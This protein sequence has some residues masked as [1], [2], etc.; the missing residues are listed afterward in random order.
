MLRTGLAQKYIVTIRNSFGGDATQTYRANT[1]GNSQRPDLSAHD[2]C[3]L[4]AFIETLL[5]QVT[6]L[7]QRSVTHYLLQSNTQTAL[8]FLCNRLRRSAPAQRRG[9]RN[10]ILAKALDG[11]MK[12]NGKSYH[13]LAAD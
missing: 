3:S 12:T 8:N 1:L 4:Y 10:G 2:M 11:V 9:Q 13:L 7:K 6:A 5:V